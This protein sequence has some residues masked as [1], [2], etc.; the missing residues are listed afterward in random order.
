MSM[1]LLGPHFTTTSTRKRKSKNKTKRLR[2]AEKEHEKFLERMGVRGTGNRLTHKHRYEMPD[3]KTRDTAPLSNQVP[4]HGPKKG[5]SKYSGT[6]IAGIVTTHKSN[7]M[8]VR[9]DNKQSFIDAAQMR[10]S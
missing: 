6:E 5:D 2:A 3:Y 9:K 8:P 10:R 1:Q 7:L 4:E